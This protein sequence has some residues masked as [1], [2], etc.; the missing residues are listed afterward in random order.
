MKLWKNTPT[1]DEY[2]PELLSNVEAAEG[3]IAVI[4]SKPINVHEMPN[5]KGIFKCGVG[6]DN[7]PFED[8]EA[9][10]IEIRLPSK[11]TQNIIFEET[12]NFAVYSIL[13]ALYKNVGDL[14]NWKKYQ[15]PFLGN[16][17][18][19][20]VGLGR[21]GTYVKEKLI[22][23]VNISTFDIRENSPEELVELTKKA[24]VVSLHIPLN[25]HTRSY[26]DAEKLGW[27][28]DGSF[29]V[30]TSRGPIVSEEDLLNE[31]K[32]SRIYAIFD[33]FWKEPYHGELKHYHPENFIMTPHI[34]ST[35]ADFLKGLA[36]D[37]YEFQD[38]LSSK[39]N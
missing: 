6:T 12:A 29:L 36:K 3:Q 5:L 20:L 25:E 8:A 7:I 15:R 11:E 4:G 1:L 39:S 24:D 19:L 28:K 27:M 16:R 30:N 10:G 32:N 14:E 9:L 33:V 13:N 18:V 2:V 26:W 34:A 35:C 22:N 21:I 17:G 37:F 23:L 38:Q 31:I